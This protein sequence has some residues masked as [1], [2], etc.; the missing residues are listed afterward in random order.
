MFLYL[1]SFTIAHYRGLSL[2]IA[3]YRSAAQR[4]AAVVEMPFK[5][6]GFCNTELNDFDALC[7]EA[8]KE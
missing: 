5:R 2:T 7:A 3:D 4:S 6:A 1:L 8:D